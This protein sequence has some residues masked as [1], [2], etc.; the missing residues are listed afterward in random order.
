MRPEQE[1]HSFA[2]IFGRML[3]PKGFF[4]HGSAFWRIREDMLWVVGMNEAGVIGFQ[5]IHF[6]HGL[7][8]ELPRSGLWQVIAVMPKG[9]VYSLEAAA[10]FFR[11]ALLEDFVSVDGIGAFFRLSETGTGCRWVFLRNWACGVLMRCGNACT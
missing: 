5:I 2:G 1:F 10:R 8:G 9:G 11:E 6:C 3:L 7:S 4:L